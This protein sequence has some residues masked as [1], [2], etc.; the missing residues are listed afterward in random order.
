[1]VVI[2]SGSEALRELVQDPGPLLPGEQL[3]KLVLDRRI[4]PR[5]RMANVGFQNEQPR[6]VG[7]ELGVAGGM[8]NGL[9]GRLDRTRD[10]FRRIA[11][12]DEVVRLGVIAFAPARADGGPE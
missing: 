9:F 3:V 2:L 11:G 5:P 12:Y 1:M 8:A 10:L 6:G 7:S 4:V